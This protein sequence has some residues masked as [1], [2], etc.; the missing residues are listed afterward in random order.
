MKHIS[1]DNAR[2][3]LWFLLLP[4]GWR[5]SRNKKRA[6]TTRWS[7]SSQKRGIWQMAKWRKCYT[8]AMATPMHN[9][10]ARVVECRSGSRG[11]RMGLDVFEIFRHWN[12]TFFLVIWRYGHFMIGSRSLFLKSKQYLFNGRSQPV[13]FLLVVILGI[14]LE[15]PE[16]PQETLTRLCFRNFFSDSSRK[17]FRNSRDFYRDFFWSTSGAPQEIS[18]EICHKLF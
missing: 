16:K 11:A 8:K 12:D 14:I 9:D 5:W 2:V 1:L 7:I 10:G 15:A 17:S 6:T 13:L 4:S 3:L 18:L